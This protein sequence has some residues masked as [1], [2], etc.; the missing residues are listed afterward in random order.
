NW[1]E[2]Q[3][4]VL[5][6]DPNAEEM[7]RHAGYSAEERQA[8][9]ADIIAK[10]LAYRSKSIRSRLDD[11]PMIGWSALMLKGLVAAYRDFNNEEY[12][13]L[14]RGIAVFIESHNTLDGKLLHQP[15]DANR[16]IPAFLDDYACS[17]EAYIALYEAT[18]EETWLT[19]A[20]ELANQALTL[21][22]D[23]ESSTLYYTAT[24]AEQLIARKSEI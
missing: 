9:L 6:V 5:F 20:R 19:R 16:S 10:L 4:N 7:I 17:I 22:Y 13:E 1:E 14:A 11:K 15:T 3:T 8:F 24:D 21:F 12:L 2:E 23:E 18:F